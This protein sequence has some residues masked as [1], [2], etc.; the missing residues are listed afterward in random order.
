MI[1]FECEK[2]GRKFNVSDEYAGKEVVCKNCQ[3]LMTVPLVTQKQ[4]ISFDTSYDPGRMFMAK[5]YEIL[6]ALL[7]H[8]REAPP[9][10][11]AS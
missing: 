4:T 2:C 10:E 5:N 1:T 3:L 9:I 7:K 6:E 11:I 8:E